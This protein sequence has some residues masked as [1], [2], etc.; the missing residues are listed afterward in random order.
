MPLACAD[1]SQSQP[2]ERMSEGVPP[3]GVAI[4]PIAPLPEGVR[5]VGDA[6]P[7]DEG[8]DGSET[9]RKPRA[10]KR[11]VVLSPSSDRGLPQAQHPR[12]SSSARPPVCVLYIS[13][14]SRPPDIFF[15]TSVARAGKQGW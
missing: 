11:A 15:R 6:V 4:A 9:P 13:S 2:S 14:N 7:M 5:D 12:R 3:A 1:G 10:G 8:E